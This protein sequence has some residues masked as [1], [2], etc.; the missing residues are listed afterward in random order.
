VIACENEFDQLPPIIH[1]PIRDNANADLNRVPMAS[2]MVQTHQRFDVGGAIVAASRTKLDE[3]ANVHPAIANPPIGTAPEVAQPMAG[4]NRY[5][6]SPLPRQTLA[7][8]SGSEWPAGAGD[9][10]ATVSAGRSQQVMRPVGIL[11]RAGEG[12]LGPGS[13]IYSHGTP[14]RVMPISLTHT[15]RNDTRLEA[16]SVAAKVGAG[17]L[18]NLPSRKPSLRSGES[19]APEA[20]MV[21]HAS[22]VSAA[23]Q[24]GRFVSL[25][26]AGEVA[27]NA[28]STVYSHGTP[29]RVVPVGLTHTVRDDTRLEAGSVVAKVGA[30]GLTNLP[31]RRPSL[32]AVESGAAE[33]GR[34][35]VSS[36]RAAASIV[37]PRPVL[38]RA[39]EIGWVYSQPAVCGQFFDL[40]IIPVPPPPPPPPL[41][42][43]IML[44]VMRGFD[45][46]QTFTIFDCEC[47]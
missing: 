37:L 45:R 28:G 10:L 1:Q 41:P 47:E 16:G 42:V 6:S 8:L 4:K 2:R 9:V 35:I 25:A 26:R 31:S 22:T 13:S 20:G 21:I 11:A 3:T 34:V 38:A 27:Q 39:S 43:A 46:S 5:G 29:A 19:P 12:I 7:T 30:G 24:P 36:S 17:G 33:A 32:R 14:A 40:E 44:P 15:V 23:M 18:A